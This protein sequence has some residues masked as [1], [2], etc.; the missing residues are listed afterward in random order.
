MEVLYKNDN[1]ISRN[2]RK[3][4]LGSNPIIQAPDEYWD[5]GASLQ[6]APSYT[7]FKILP[8]HDRAKGKAWLFLKN[9]AE[10]IERYR[11]DMEERRKKAGI[12]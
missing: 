8:I 2:Y 6:L 3:Q 5:I 10:L 1:D 4:L 11:N 7:D 12:S 9:A